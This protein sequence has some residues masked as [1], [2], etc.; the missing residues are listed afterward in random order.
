[1]EDMLIV[2]K[3]PKYYST[4]EEGELSDDDEDGIVR[5]EGRG[6]T[7]E[8]MP[9][10][11]NNNNKHYCRKPPLFNNHSRGI[12]DNFGNNMRDSSCGNGAP[13]PLSPNRSGE[14]GPSGYFKKRRLPPPPSLS[15]GMMN[16]GGRRDN[17]NPMS[18]DM[19]GS[20][21][22][23]GVSGGYWAPPP[24]LRPHHPSRIPQQLPPMSHHP[25]RPSPPRC[26]VGPGVENLG[27]GGHGQLPSGNRDSLPPGPWQDNRRYGPMTPRSNFQLWEKKRRMRESRASLFSGGAHQMSSLKENSDYEDLLRKYRSIQKQIANL[28]EEENLAVQDKSTQSPGNK[29]WD[30][31]RTISVSSKGS[32]SHESSS[33]SNKKT[34]SRWNPPK[35]GSESNDKRVVFVNSHAEDEDD[36]IEELRR[37]ALASTS[38][39]NKPKPS[40]SKSSQSKPVSR[41]RS[42]TLRRKTNSSNR[43]SYK[44]ES[45]VLREQSCNKSG[46]KRKL[47]FLKHRPAYRSCRRRLSSSEDKSKLVNNQRREINKILEVDD[48]V[49]QIERLAKYLSE[50]KKELAINNKPPSCLSQLNETKSDGKT[51]KVLQDNYEEVAMEIDSDDGLVAVNEIED[52]HIQREPSLMSSISELPPASDRNGQDLNFESNPKNWVNLIPPPPPPPPLP[53][54]PP[55]PPPPPLVDKSEKVNPNELSLLVSNVDSSS[56]VPYTLDPLLSP[57]VQPLMF[58]GLVPPLPPPPPLPDEKPPEKPPEPDYEE[59]EEE[60]KLLRAQLL[61]SMAIRRKESVQILPKAIV[62]DTSGKESPLSPRSQSPHSTDANLPD[63]KQPPQQQP[64]CAPKIPKHPSVVINLAEDSTDSEHEAEPETQ[65]QNILSGIDQFLKDARKSVETK[66]NSMESKD[67][68]NIKKNI[69]LNKQEVDLYTADRGFRELEE[70]YVAQRKLMLQDQRELK[71]LV[72][73]ASKVLTKIKST[74]KK[75]EIFRKNLKNSDHLVAMYHKQDIKIKDKIQLVKIQLA[76]N[77]STVLQLEKNLLQIGKRLYGACYQPRTIAVDSAGNKRVL[78]L[79]SHNQLKPKIEDIPHKR[80][81]LQQMQQQYALMLQKLQTQANKKITKSSVLQ[82]E[83]ISLDCTEEAETASQQIAEKIDSRRR[84]M[85]SLNSKMKPE[86]IQNKENIQPDIRVPQQLDKT[87]Y[88][89]EMPENSQLANLKTILHE[90]MQNLIEPAQSKIVSWE[91]FS[92]LTPP[93]NSIPYPKSDNQSLNNLK[94]SQALRLYKPY[95]SPL[96]HF[97]AYRFSPFLRTKENLSLS[98]QSFSHKLN[99]KN[100]LCQYDLQGTCNDQQCKSQ[101]LKDYSMST[102]EILQDIVSY[103]PALTGAS[104]EQSGEKIAGQ[105]CDYVENIMN[106]NQGRMTVDELCLLQISKVN[107]FVHHV[108]P[109]TMF[110]EP[111]CWKPNQESLPDTVVDIDKIYTQET[112]LN[113]LFLSSKPDVL[114]EWEDII[115]EQD[116]RYFDIGNNTAAIL[117]LE[118]AVLENPQN[119]QLWLKL[120]YKKLSSRS[121]DAESGHLDQALNVLARGLENMKQSPDLW[122]YYLQLYSQHPD[123]KKDLVDMCC[124]AIQNAPSYTLWWQYLCATENYFSKIEICKQMHQYLKKQEPS[125]VVSQHITEVSLYRLGITVVSN[126]FKTGLLFFKNLLQTPSSHDEELM[127][128]LRP[129]DRALLWLCYIYLHEFQR[130]PDQ[131]YDSTGHFLDHLFPKSLH[132]DWYSHSKLQCDI[133]FLQK[134]YEDCLTFCLQTDGERTDEHDKVSSEVYCSFL[135]LLH[136][137]S[138]MD[139]ALSIGREVLMKWPHLD[140]VWLSMAEFYSADKNVTAVWQIF[141]EA[142]KTGCYSAKLYLYASHMALSLTDSECALRYLEQASISCFLID[143]TDSRCDPNILYCC[144]LRQTIPLDYKIPDYCENISPEVLQKNQLYFWLTYCLLLELQSDYSQAIEGYETALSTMKSTSDIAQVWLHYLNY[145]IRQAA[146]EGNSAADKLQSLVIRSLTCLPSRVETSTSRYWH[147]HQHHNKIIDLYINCLES[148]EQKMAAYDKFLT[149]M[150][151]NIEL[152]LRAVDLAVSCNDMWRAL[153]FCQTGVHEKLPCISLWNKVTALTVLRCSQIEVQQLF[154]KAVRVLPYAVSLWKHFLL[155]EVT[156]GAK[157]NVLQIIQRCQQLGLNIDGFVKTISR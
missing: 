48:P 156:I 118:A 153:S 105:I 154:I 80:Q 29:N 147:D 97:R 62:D 83:K 47:G 46:I 20:N 95:K 53:P 115:E 89:F 39:N 5:N 121:S 54:P 119:E 150:P 91:N 63:K 98:S 88:N 82:L 124:V 99:C 120:A 133:K 86:I 75:C 33:E 116:V 6:E 4:K 67:V 3:N 77:E 148:T 8:N 152:I 111:R 126:R 72:T 142:L 30:S 85:I 90:K 59:D 92:H 140:D 16:P 155:F 125:E 102:Q 73:Q 35:S 87:E 135:K 64:Y 94:M 10:E 21:S 117:D 2:V 128:M 69:S 41:S 127:S 44:R 1:M 17:N 93:S 15:C 58:H 138:R 40:V 43:S 52:I 68:S 113:P 51:S 131:L 49:E 107:E 57:N 143:I 32:Q 134:L 114:S 25:Y 31:Y 22:G 141:D 13:F 61:Q 74:E 36:E 45:T 132:I 129:S 23:P 9:V 123:S 122:Q 109:H 71:A 12:F 24:P 157:S 146:H 66:K 18:S 70:K 145:Q 110:F 96:L 60:E 26:P 137:Q 139:E 50:K 14:D 28:D 106:Q 130:L 81:Q 144:L 79:L 65:K 55:P 11:N 7:D 38:E 19:C 151:N 84:S 34:K 100:I 56:Q 108:P 112:D 76:H 78:P 104:K 37:I 136:S 103:A 149:I 42:E 27:P 101:H